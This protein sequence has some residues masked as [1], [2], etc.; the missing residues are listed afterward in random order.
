MTFNLRFFSSFLTI[1]VITFSTALPTLAAELT[2]PLYTTELSTIIGR[3][4]QAILGITGA[5]ALLMFILGGFQWLI[6]GGSPEKVKKGRE[7]LT[8]AVIGLAVII[9]AYMLVSTVVTALES[10]TVA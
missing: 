9:G 3:L 1:T 4:I 7:T 5:I 6:S 10:G 8:W 2:N